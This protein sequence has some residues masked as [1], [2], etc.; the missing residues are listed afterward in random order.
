MT[1]LTVKIDDRKA[2][3]LRTRA[4]HYGLPLEDLLAASIESL[5]TQPEP[6]FKRA[7]DHVL[8]KNSELY[9]R[10]A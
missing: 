2:E 5:L 3:A 1:T 10:L 6:D 8:A 4:E 9:R 7:V